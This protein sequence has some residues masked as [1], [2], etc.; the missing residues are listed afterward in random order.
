MSYSVFMGAGGEVLCN[1]ERWRESDPQSL[2]WQETASLYSWVS[3]EAL[4]KEQQ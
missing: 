3:S 4:K 2:G 1:A